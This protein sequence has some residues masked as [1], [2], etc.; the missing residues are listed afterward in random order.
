M[1]I[2]TDREIDDADEI[3][4]VKTPLDDSM[5]KLVQKIRDYLKGKTSRLKAK[6]IAEQIFCVAKLAENCEGSRK[7][8]PTLEAQLKSS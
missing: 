6:R 5:K 2:F 1:E 4:Q 3:S 7:I 8:F